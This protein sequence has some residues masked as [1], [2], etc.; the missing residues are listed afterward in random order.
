MAAAYLFHLCQAHAFIDGNK[1]TAL[2]AC[3][4]FLD[5]NGS[6][7]AAPPDDL[8]EV[9]VAVADGSLGKADLTKRLRTMIQKQRK[10]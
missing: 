6:R 3:H 5:A 8:F 1:R 2:L 9:V 10:A 4:A 7:F